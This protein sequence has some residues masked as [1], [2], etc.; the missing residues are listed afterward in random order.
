MPGT[1]LPG[2]L[3][4]SPCARPVGP[5]PLSALSSQCA[6][7]I[8]LSHLTLSSAA[9]LCP[10]LQWTGPPGRPSISSG[11]TC[12]TRTPH[13]CPNP[14]HPNPSS[15]TEASPSPQVPRPQA[16]DT[17]SQDPLSPRPLCHTSP[18]SRS[19]VSCIPPPRLWLAEATPCPAVLPLSP[20]TPAAGVTFVEHK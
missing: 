17:S 4:A 20:S 11:A 13:R 14:C 9:L 7:L 12:P 3:W 5:R 1:S 10:M 16:G 8:H 19:D 18:S 2:A 6:G 15:S